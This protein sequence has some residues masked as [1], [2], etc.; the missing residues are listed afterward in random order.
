MTEEETEVQRDFFVAMP[1]LLKGRLSLEEF[2]IAVRNALHFIALTEMPAPG[3]VPVQ[4]AL[5]EP[6]AKDEDC[7]TI[8]L[9]LDETLVHCR[10]DMLVDIKHNFC[11]HFAES[12]ATGWIYVRPFARLFLEIVARLFEV[13]VFTA[14]SSSYADQVLDT[15]DPG[16]RCISRRLYRQHCSEVSG[17]YVKDMS[18]LGR[19]LDRVLLVDNS[20]VSLA[21]CPDNGV[22]VSSWTAEQANDRELVDLLLLLQ[23][24][25]QYSSV[26]DFLSHRYGLRAFLDAL[27]SSPELLGE[28]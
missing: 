13:V 19:P 28:V 12:Q 2:P 27:R 22:L 25:M 14:S 26:S 11:V 3:G 5:L 21:M 23:Q 16:G 18:A 10:T 9:D 20:P 1:H 4:G 24:C 7:L 8:V 6:R 17:G 15:L